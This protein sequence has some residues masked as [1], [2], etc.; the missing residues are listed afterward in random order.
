MTLYN[1]L[2]RE[3]SFLITLSTVEVKI[4]RFLVLTKKLFYYSS[5][6]KAMAIKLHLS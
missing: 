6:F 2:A 5:A 1:A 4:S 3:K